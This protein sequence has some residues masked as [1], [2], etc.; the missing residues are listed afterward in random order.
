MTFSIGHNTV[1]EY[2]RLSTCK[3]LFWFIDLEDLVHIVHP[4]V[5][6]GMWQASRSWWEHVT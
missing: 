5:A 2:L 6:L 4:C 1:T 3:F